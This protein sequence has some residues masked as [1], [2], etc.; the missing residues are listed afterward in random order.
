[1]QGWFEEGTKL[2]LHER[3]TAILEFGIS[4]GF[5]CKIMWEEHDADGFISQGLTFFGAGQPTTLHPAKSHLHRDKQVWTV[6]TSGGRY[7]SKLLGSQTIL[8]THSEIKEA[9]G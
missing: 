8:F 3:K 1:M 6:E 4:Q 2:Q 7:Q 5:Q 9:C